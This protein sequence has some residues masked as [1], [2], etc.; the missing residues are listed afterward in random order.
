[1]LSS[2]GFS[3]DEIRDL[4]LSQIKVLTAAVGRLKAQETVNNMSSMRVAYH[5]EPK[6]FSKTVKDLQRK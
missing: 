5:A 1:M 3:F 4:H 6:D 2:V